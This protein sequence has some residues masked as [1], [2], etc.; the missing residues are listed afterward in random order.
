MASW[1]EMLPW[2]GLPFQPDTWEP[3]ARV[4]CPCPGGVP[5]RAGRADPRAVA[6]R[7]QRELKLHG[8]GRRVLAVGSQA[9]ADLFGRL[10]EQHQ[11]AGEHKDVPAPPIKQR[12]GTGLSPGDAL[13]GSVP[14]AERRPCV[15][16]H[17]SARRAQGS[18]WRAVVA[19]RVMWQRDRGQDRLGTGERT[20]AGTGHTLGPGS[21]SSR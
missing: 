21:R 9:R 17:G 13:P 11:G 2:S 18:L 20:L 14:G 8:R 6:P 12:P 3:S 19:S 1:E 15:P 16:E 10:P 4:T 7:E 5:A